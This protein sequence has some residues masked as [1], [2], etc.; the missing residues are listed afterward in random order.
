MEVR[1][2]LRKEGEEGHEWLDSMIHD[3]YG[4]Y[5][6]YG[7]SIGVGGYSFHIPNINPH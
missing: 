6:L 5:V 7:S 3:I 2:G 1:E 4:L